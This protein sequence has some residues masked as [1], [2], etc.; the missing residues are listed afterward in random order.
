MQTIRGRFRVGD[1]RHTR[2]KRHEWSI[3]G[4][5]SEDAV[6]R[7]LQSVIGA[8]YQAA[9]GQRAIPGVTGMLWITCTV[10]LA[11]SMAPQTVRDQQDG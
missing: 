6:A 10:L 11:R 8:R 3:Y 9:G 4:S 7:H 2:A 1:G 5:G